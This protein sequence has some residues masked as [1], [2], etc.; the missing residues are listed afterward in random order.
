MH[1]MVDLETMGTAPGSVIAAI[2]A[3]AFDPL[4]GEFGASFYRAVSMASCQRAG[5]TLDA[6][7]VGWWLRQGDAARA[8]LLGER[9]DLITALAHF[10][11]F[12][13][14]A[15]GTAFWSH[16]ANFD[17]PLLAAAY[18]AVGSRSPWGYT[19]SRCTQTIFA[20]AGVS[21]DRAAGTHHNA[22]DDARAQAEAVCAAYVALGL[23][24]RSERC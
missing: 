22:L 19:A 10:E 14:D 18:R 23:T 1:I 2:G 5:L 24:G 17:E 16:G 15:G 20:L 12:W 6:D 3:V 9:A 11:G 8:A 4:T 21:V 7:T 13:R